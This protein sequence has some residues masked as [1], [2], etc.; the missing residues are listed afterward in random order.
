MPLLPLARQELPWYFAVFQ[1]FYLYVPRFLVELL[2]DLLQNRG[3]QMLEWNLASHFV[4][5]IIE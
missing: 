4:H 2:N 5:V 3:G 1:N